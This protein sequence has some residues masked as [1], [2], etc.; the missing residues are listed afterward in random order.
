ML[1]TG[2]GKLAYLRSSKI[3]R[4]LNAC[5]CLT[6]GAPGSPARCQCPAP[7]GCWPCSGRPPRSLRS[8][9]TRSRS[10]SRGRGQSWGSRQG[11]C[12]RWPGHCRTRCTWCRWWPHC[13]G[14]QQSALPVTWSGSRVSQVARAAHLDWGEVHLQVRRLARVWTGQSLLSRGRGPSL[15]PQQTARTNLR[16]Q[17]NEQYII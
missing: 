12:S 2:G 7:A 3:S 16:W 10:R 13:Y 6:C 4:L 9:Q 8:S 1:T 5:L 11:W 15:L 17:N 14:P